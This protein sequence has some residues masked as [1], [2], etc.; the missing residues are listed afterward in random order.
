MTYSRVPDSGQ[1]SIERGL[2]CQ[3]HQGS[4]E[5]VL[6]WDINSER[7]KTSLILNH[8]FTQYVPIKHT[9]GIIAAIRAHS[10]DVLHP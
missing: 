9:L 4:H 1:R 7:D 6:E 8:S 2:S 3:M 5:S 10:V